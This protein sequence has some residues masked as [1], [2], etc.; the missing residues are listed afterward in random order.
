M[1]KTTQVGAG[2]ATS[3]EKANGSGRSYKAKTKTKEAKSSKHQDRYKISRKLEK[4]LRKDDLRDGYTKT[5]SVGGEISG[6]NGLATPKKE[7]ELL[8]HTRKPKASRP[9]IKIGLKSCR[10]RK[11][12]DLDA[13]KARLDPTHAAPTLFEA[14]LSCVEEILSVNSVDLPLEV[15]GQ[16]LGGE[17]VVSSET[18]LYEGRA[19]N[20]QSTSD[21]IPPHLESEDRP[22]C[23]S[24]S[25][26]PPPPALW[27]S[28][29]IYCWSIS[30]LLWMLT[31]LCPPSWSSPDETSWNARLSFLMAIVKSSSLSEAMPLVFFSAKLLS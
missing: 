6:L 12:V 31:S 15:K 14:E 17:V 19:Y 7:A 21:S 18:D 10:K 23:A 24:G 22:E 26:H 1:A 20:Q 13:P 9:R 2:G 3:E 27:A 16:D 29:R 28:V 30:E 25:L 8:Q 5:S 4:R 11:R